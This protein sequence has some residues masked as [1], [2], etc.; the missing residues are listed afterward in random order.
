M[1]KKKKKRKRFT[2]YTGN[3]AAFGFIITT[4]P[5]TFS[6]GVSKK[7]KIVVFFVKIVNAGSLHAELY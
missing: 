5:L 4:I 6:I 2:V 1:K 7:K 3:V